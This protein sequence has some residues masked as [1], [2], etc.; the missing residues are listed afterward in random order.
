MKACQVPGLAA[1]V[2]AGREQ[3]TFTTSILAGL[4]RV[5]A[6]RDALL[7]ADPE[8]LDKLLKCANSSP[9]GG[10]QIEVRI[11]LYHPPKIES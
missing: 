7:E 9:L 3:N 5:P 8:V 6:F 10:Q 4:G 11:Q 1:A 2:L